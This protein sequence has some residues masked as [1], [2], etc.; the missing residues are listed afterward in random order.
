MHKFYFMVVRLILL[1][2]PLLVL[3]VT[4]SSCSG[5]DA[6]SVQMSDDDGN[7]DGGDDNDDGNGGDNNDNDDDG[8]NDD[9]HVEYPYISEVGLFI[10]DGDDPLTDSEPVFSFS[11]DLSVILNPATAC[12]LTIGKDEKHEGKA[13]MLHLS[14]NNVDIVTDNSC[15]N[16]P[17]EITADDFE[18]SWWFNQWKVE[19]TAPGATLPDYSTEKWE[20]SQ[21][22]VSV[23]P[24]KDFYTDPHYGVLPKK[25]SFTFNNVRIGYKD[26]N[27]VKKALRV[28]GIV[29]VTK[30]D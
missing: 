24:S 2:L 1:C 23:N 12:Y 25:V 11:N 19:L 6:V 30:H 28:H 16:D 5:D 7:N 26:E 9:S 17:L 13:W 20:Y 4:T 21:G 15:F 22:S 3:Q 10:F 18:T 14:S 8:D 29:E 27:G